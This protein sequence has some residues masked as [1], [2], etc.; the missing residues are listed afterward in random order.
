MKKAAKAAQGMTF[1]GFHVPC[2]ERCFIVTPR[3]EAQRQ[4]SE[5]NMALSE[6]SLE[7]Y[8]QLYVC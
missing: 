1:T 4:A 3:S 5:H 2:S 6:E 7:E 8:R